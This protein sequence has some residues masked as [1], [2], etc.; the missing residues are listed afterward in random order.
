MCVSVCKC[1]CVWVHV[2]VCVE[3]AHTSCVSACSMYCDHYST[4]PPLSS[5]DAPMFNIPNVT[6]PVTEYFLEEILSMTRC[7]VASILSVIDSA[8]MYSI[9]T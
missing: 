4:A 1:V 5:D 9:S 7:D 6:Y 3:G 8:C 2:C